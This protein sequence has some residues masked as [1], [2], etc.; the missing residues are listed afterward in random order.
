M[1]Y[2][3]QIATRRGENAMEYEIIS[4]T[5]SE[6]EAILKDYESSK[7]SKTLRVISAWNDGATFYALVRYLEKRSYEH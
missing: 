6:V 7:S 4:G 3:I 1:H 2:L 5:K